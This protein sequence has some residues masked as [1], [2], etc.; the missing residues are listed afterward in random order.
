MNPGEI[1]HGE[2]VTNHGR[3]RTLGGIGECSAPH[4]E[5]HGTHGPL[6]T[7]C[8]LGHGPWGGEPALGRVASRF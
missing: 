4:P 2:D 6:T 7:L 1:R 8:I 3:T 5:P